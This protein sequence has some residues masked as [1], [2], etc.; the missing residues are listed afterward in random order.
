MAK[1]ECF[2]CKRIT[3]VIAPRYRCTFCNYPMHKYQ[4]TE[5]KQPENK[6]IKDF[7]QNDYSQSIVDRVKP[8]DPVEKKSA[9]NVNSDK[10]EEAK[11]KIGPGVNININTPSDQPKNFMEKLEEQVNI[12]IQPKENPPKEKNFVQRLNEK[13]NINI[14]TGNNQPEKNFVQRLNE[15]VNIDK[16]ENEPK[17]NFV[18]RIE[19]SAKPKP[20]VQPIK[21]DKFSKDTLDRQEKL[22]EIFNAVRKPTTEEIIFHKNTNPEKDGKIVAGWLVVHTE[23][24]SPVAY[25]LFEGV[26]I[27][28]RPDGPHRVDIKIEEDRYVSREHCYI[29]IQKD[30]LHRFVYILHDG[31]N[32]AGEEKPSTNGTFVNGLE[33]KMDEGS[34]VYLKDGDIVQVGETKLAF[35]NTY[36]SADYHEAANSVIQTDYT[37]TVAIQFTP[38]Q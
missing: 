13:V 26:N 8:A 4:E 15:K 21:S 2:N 30:F 1:V 17:K 3:P 38:N 28:G 32:K 19:E 11:E 36:E 23:N 16:G 12:N 25:E 29:D 9:F 18:Q 34:I 20:A 27:I 35:K 33:D 31:Q 24:K 6:V 37:K 7:K 22:K 5:E 14:N 10:K